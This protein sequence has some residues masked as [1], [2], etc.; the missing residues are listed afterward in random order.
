[1]IYFY[2]TRLKPGEVAQFSFV[3]KTTWG[4]EMKC[5]GC[6]IDSIRDKRYRVIWYKCGEDIY[7][8]SPNGPGEN[9]AAEKFI[10]EKYHKWKR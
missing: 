5:R 6:I 2:E 1:M 3:L 9:E 7:P 10:M 8:C 4:G